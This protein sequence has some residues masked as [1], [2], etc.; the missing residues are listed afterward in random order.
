MRSNLVLTALDTSICSSSCLYCSM[1]NTISPFGTCEIWRSLNRKLPTS[2]APKSNSLRTAVIILSKFSSPPPITSSACTPCTSWICPPVRRTNAYGST[3]QLVKPCWMSDFLSL[4]HNFFSALTSAHTAFLNRST[5]SCSTLS[6]CLT[7]SGGTIKMFLTSSPPV[8]KAVLMSSE[9]RRYSCEETH[10]MIEAP[11]AADN[12]GLSRDLCQNWIPKAQQ[13]RSAFTFPHD[14]HVK[15]H[16][17]RLILSW[18]T[19]FS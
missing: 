4:P 5:V 14:F 18:S 10:C 13:Q 8:R 2:H 16:L 3:T 6:V 11:D 7:S 19:I 15:T 9:I 1:S 17:A 12:V